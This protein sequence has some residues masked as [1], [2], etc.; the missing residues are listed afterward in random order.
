MSCFK[1]ILIRYK[2]KSSLFVSFSYNAKEPDRGEQWPFNLCLFNI[3]L[4]LGSLIKKLKQIVAPCSELP[5][6]SSSY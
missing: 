1:L 3:W 2:E 5:L 4:E 6:A